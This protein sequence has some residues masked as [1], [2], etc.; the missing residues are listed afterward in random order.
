MSRAFG[1]VKKLTRT[2]HA[3]NKQWER[4]LRS[5]DEPQS[6]VRVLSTHTGQLHKAYSARYEDSEKE[7]IDL[8]T[9]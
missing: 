2:F 8:N 7:L 3:G 4:G 1:G 6:M 9:L 5:D